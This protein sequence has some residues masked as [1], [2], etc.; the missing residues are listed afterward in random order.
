MNLWVL[1]GAGTALAATL[2]AVWLFRE[3]SKEYNEIGPYR[4]GHYVNALL[5]GLAGAGVLVV[6][7]GYA[8][9]MVLIGLG[10]I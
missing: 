7:L 8:F 9:G 3:F 1:A 6:G 10:K 4:D 2:V 5:S